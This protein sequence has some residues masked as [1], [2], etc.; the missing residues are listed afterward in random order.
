M[1]LSTWDCLRDYPRPA[2]KT[3][4]AQQKAQTRSFQEAP[5]RNS[6]P[7]S[8]AGALG[9]QSYKAGSANFGQMSNRALRSI[10]MWVAGKRMVTRS[11]PL[12]PNK[13]RDQALSLFPARSP[14]NADGQASERL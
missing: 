6:C 13:G 4:G 9:G 1:A 2:C 5:D 8:K 3:T 12:Q 10:M 14:E 7:P 11:A